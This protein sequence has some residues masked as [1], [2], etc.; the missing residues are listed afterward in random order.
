MGLY[1]YDHQVEIEDIISKFLV[2]WLFDITA[3]LIHTC[4]WD[5]KSD[6]RDKPKFYYLITVSYIDSNGL[7]ISKVF[8]P[9]I[10]TI[11]FNQVFSPLSSWI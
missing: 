5:T 7:V 4:S 10:S 9:L 1:W 3:H 2:I 11:H 8:Y 6:L